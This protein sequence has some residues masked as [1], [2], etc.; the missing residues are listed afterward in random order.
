MNKT[1]KMMVIML[2]VMLLGGTIT[3]V[4]FLNISGKDGK[5]AKASISDMV[6]Y[7]YE[8]PEM[9]TDL[10]DGSFVKIQFRIITDGKGARKEIEQRE[11]QIKN[12]LIKELGT[13]NEK[14]FKSGLPELENK[15]KIKLNE[16]MQEGKVTDVYTVNKILQ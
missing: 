13:M 16:V 4:I 7:S 11:F 1:I 14:Q 5:E 15:M 2:V 6:E 3:T 12:I 10:D 8:T 9:T